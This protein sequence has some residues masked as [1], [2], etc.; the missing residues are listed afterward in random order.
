MALTQD[1][2]NSI[3]ADFVKPADI[4]AS[5]QPKVETPVVETPVTPVVEAKVETPVV[6]VVET[7]KEEVKPKEETPTPESDLQKFLK[8]N[9]ISS[10]DELKKR[11]ATPEKQKSEDEILIEA[12]NYGLAK[13]SIKLSDYE[14]AI[15][16]KDAPDSEVAYQD[17]A[18]KQL[19]R[20]SE[21]TPE[22]IK[23][24]FDKKF[25]EVNIDD[26]SGE[27]KVTYDQAEIKEYASDVRKQKFAPI[28]N[29][30][31]EF[32]EYQKSSQNNAA[33]ESEIKDF[34]NKIPKSFQIDSDGE[35]YDIN[36]DDKTAEQLKVEFESL[37]RY[38]ANKGEDRSVFNLDKFI[39][40]SIWGDEKRR[41]DALAIIKKGYADAKVSEALL[42]F[43]NQQV[44]PLDSGE[45]QQQAFNEE[46]ELQNL[47]KQRKAKGMR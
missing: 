27:P 40:N 29:L 12:V 17:F 15:K 39:E 38:M 37:Y 47:E 41:N 44:K 46:A 5:K 33:V 11:L 22:Q 28:E 10:P 13:N 14:S 20:N 31:K 30:K 21:L 25:G 34:K 23:T 4:E 9:N 35:K 7:P 18:A 8:E 1:K 6:P 16:L 42:P 3:N 32:G 19:A 24:R 36:F 26:V 45:K 43:K 2:L